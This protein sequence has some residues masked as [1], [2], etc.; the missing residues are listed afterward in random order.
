MVSLSRGIG[1]LG[2]LILA[3]GQ[4][5]LIVGYYYHELA[6]TLIGATLFAAA[7][8]FLVFSYLTR[9]NPSPIDLRRKA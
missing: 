2:T 1:G 9:H 6:P 3:I 5:L 8:I 7:G 4:I